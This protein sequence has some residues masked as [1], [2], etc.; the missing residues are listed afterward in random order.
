[1]EREV[2]QHHTG[3]NTDFDIRPG[4]AVGP[5]NSINSYVVTSGDFATSVQFQAGPL[6]GD[7]NG[8]T[9]EALLEVAAMRLEAFNQGEFACMYNTIAI[10]KIRGAIETLKERAE[11]RAERGVLGREAK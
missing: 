7:P 1:M 8:L 4:K 11:D 6:N 10:A 5:A 3:R 9:I 2:L